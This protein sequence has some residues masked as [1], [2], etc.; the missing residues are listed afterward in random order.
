MEGDPCDV[1]D[2]EE[3][4]EGGTQRW[5]GELVMTSTER[6][7]LGGRCRGR[8]LVPDVMRNGRLSF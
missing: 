2:K 3:T 4:G 8:G 6:H 7:G 1:R 5:A